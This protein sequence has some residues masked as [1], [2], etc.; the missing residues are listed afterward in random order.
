MLMLCVC[1]DHNMTMFGPPQV[2]G[3]THRRGVSLWQFAELLIAHG[4]I[5]A[6]NL[7]GGGSSTFVEDGILASYPSDHW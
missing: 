7:D 2:D 5:N 1:S 6:I 3:Q 4:V